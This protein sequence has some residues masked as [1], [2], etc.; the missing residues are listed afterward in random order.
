MGLWERITTMVGNAQERHG[1]VTNDRFRAFET[2]DGS[3]LVYDRTNHAA[4]IQSDLTVDVTATRGG[5][6]STSDADR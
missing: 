2:G 1:T 6:R 4:W 5:M 3:L